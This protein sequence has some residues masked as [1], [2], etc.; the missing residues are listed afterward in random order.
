MSSETTFETDISSLA[1]LERILWNQSE[2][3]SARAKAASDFCRWARSMEY[4]RTRANKAP[5]ICPFTK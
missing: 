1:E 4:R 3:V 2:R 5:L